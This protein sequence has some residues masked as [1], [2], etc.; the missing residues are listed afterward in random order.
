M[1]CDKKKQV[2]NIKIFNLGK[3]G[4]LYYF[5]HSHLKLKK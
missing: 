3:L 4:I 1:R 5:N 2:Q